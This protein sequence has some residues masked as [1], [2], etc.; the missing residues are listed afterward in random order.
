MRSA[1]FAVTVLFAAVNIVS[2][3]P[4]SGTSDSPQAIIERAIRASGGA[5]KLAKIKTMR[6][7]MTGVNEVMGQK[8]PTVAELMI[9]LPDK[10]KMDCQANAAAP[11]N[12]TAV[13]DGKEAFVIVMGQTTLLPGDQ[14][15]EFKESMH[16]MALSCLTPLLRDK[17]Y[18]LT[19]LG[20][21][22]VNGRPAEG[23]KVEREGYRDVRMYFDKR[24]NLLV[25]TARRTLD[26]ASMKEVLQETI[27]SNHKDCSGVQWPTKTVSFTDNVKSAEFEATDIRFSDKIDE[28]AFKKP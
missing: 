15:K 13:F 16:F 3:T 18:K 23:V 28:D 7:K 4:R 12:I 1:V 27:H 14:G 5:E 22:K 26:Q 8:Q 21:I 10:I 20:E 19:S 17:R 25:K 6:M 2:A 24:T 11:I 9:Q